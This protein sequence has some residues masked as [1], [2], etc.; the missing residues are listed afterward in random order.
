MYGKTVQVS[1]VDALSLDLALQLRTVFTQMWRFSRVPALLSRG[2]VVERMGR[3]NLVSQ[4]INSAVVGENAFPEQLSAKY[5]VK[6][7]MQWFYSWKIL[8]IKST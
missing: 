2:R 7:G 8:Y 4:E 5:Q 1:V 3:D 6:E